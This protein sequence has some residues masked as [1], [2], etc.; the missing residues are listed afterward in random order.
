LVLLVVA[1]AVSVSAASAGNINGANKFTLYAGQDV[2]CDLSG[3]V[4]PGTA[5]SSF[6]VLQYDKS[7]NQVGATVSLKGALPN[8]TYGVRILQGD[9]SSCFADIGSITTNSQGNGSTNV[10]APATSTTADVFVEEY[11]TFTFFSSGPTFYN[12]A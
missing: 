1:G 8:T 10:T 2:F 5:T 12:H 7:L 4:A 11:N 3:F 9:F 6:A